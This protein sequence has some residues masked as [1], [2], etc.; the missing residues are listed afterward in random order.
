MALL[1]P[2]LWTASSYSSHHEEIGSNEAIYTIC[3]Y[4][5]HENL[6]TSNFTNVK[7]AKVNIMELWLKQHFIALIS[8]CDTGPLH[9]PNW[10]TFLTSDV[11][12]R[13]TH[14][15]KGGLMCKQFFAGLLIFKF[16]KT[17]NVFYY[18]GLFDLSV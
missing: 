2:V 3:I 18:V 12:V 16:I 10:A 4:R 13:L 1:R 5:H 14:C 6:N 9:L 7:S 8:K 11:L 15:I 17:Y